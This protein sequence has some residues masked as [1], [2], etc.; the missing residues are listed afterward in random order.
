M[1]IQL[2]ELEIKDM[3]RYSVIFASF[4]LAAV[5]LFLNIV[6]LRLRWSKL[7]I[8]L[9]IC[10]IPFFLTIIFGTICYFDQ[11][12]ERWES[13]TKISFLHSWMLVAGF[14]LYFVVTMSPWLFLECGRDVSLWRHDSLWRLLVCIFGLVP[15]AYGFYMKSKKSRWWLIVVGGAVVICV[16]LGIIAFLCSQQTLCCGIKME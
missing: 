12:S 14:F 9:F 2:S 6:P 7:T 16:G 10:I 13:W 8:I 11:T 1:G 3:I 5:S 4:F 15:I